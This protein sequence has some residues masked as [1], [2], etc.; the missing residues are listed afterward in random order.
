[1]TA[2]GEAAMANDELDI[3]HPVEAREASLPG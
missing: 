2:S 1:V 3:K